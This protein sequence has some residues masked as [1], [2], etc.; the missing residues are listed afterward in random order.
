MLQ[1]YRLTIEYDG[2]PYCGWQYQPNLPTVEGT[3]LHAIAQ[4][5]LNVQL[6]SGAGRTD[7]GVHATGQ[8][9]VLHALP[10]GN[11]IL[12]PTRLM[13]ALNGKLNGKRQH[14]IAVIQA[15]T[16]PIEWHARFSAISREYR[17]D[18]LNRYA[19]PT[20]QK[21]RVWHVPK[22]LNLAAMQ[23][24]AQH[25]VGYH[26]FTSFRHH[27]CT[28]KSPMKSI[29]T[30]ALTQVGD[31]ISLTI[32]AP[33]FL[34]SQ[35]R[36]IMGTLVDIGNARWPAEYIKT[37]LSARNRATAG[38]CAPPDGLYLTKVFYE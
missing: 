3:L 29:N 13:A 4:F 38:Q 9:V 10:T 19:Q 33:S 31:I 35:V 15:D 12:S 28:A 36:N 7:A 32:N 21:H 6:F 26:D 8:M 25:L 22:P 37:I 23:Q 18:V 27:N 17:Y 16:P 34:H 1:Y 30:I 24:A 5:P 14:P 20:V 11:S 2:T